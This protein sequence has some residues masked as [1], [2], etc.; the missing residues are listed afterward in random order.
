MPFGGG[1]VI[2]ELLGGAESEMTRYDA[3]ALVSISEAP[4]RAAARAACIGHS[5]VHLMIGA[6]V[7]NCL[8]RFR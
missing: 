8:N 7:H 6:S 5:G 1:A 3:V 4:G 2:D